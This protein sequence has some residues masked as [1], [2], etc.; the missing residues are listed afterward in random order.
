MVDA[1]TF[2]IIRNP[3]RKRIALRIADDGVLEILSPEGV[4]EEF[5]QQI[6]ERETAV[7]ARLRAHSAGVIRPQAVFAEG[8]MFALLGKFY[9]L[10]LSS[11][12]KIF[13]GERFIIP[14][15]S[16]QTMQSDLISLYLEIAGKYLMKRAEAMEKLTGLHAERYRISSADRRWGSCNSRQVIALSWKLIQCPPET[17]DYV[18]IHELA[19]LKELNHSVKFWKIVGNFCPDYLDRR[20]KL[21]E[22]SRSLPPL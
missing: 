18:I 14:R 21:N 11:R 22:F 2:R 7:I 15:G 6:A 20:R 19:H 4:P 17:I 9:P 8:R 5:L 1:P 12:L 16:H 3:R 10:H 13:D